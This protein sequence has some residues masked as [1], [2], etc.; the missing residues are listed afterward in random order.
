MSVEELQDKIGK[1]TVVI[2]HKFKQLEV[3]MP[4]KSNLYLSF[5][6]DAVLTSQGPDWA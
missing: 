5:S 6:R 4:S 2:D 1:Q 3:S